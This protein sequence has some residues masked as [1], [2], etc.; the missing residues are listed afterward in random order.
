MTRISLSSFLLASVCAGGAL[1]QGNAAQG[2][3]LA[4]QICAACHVVSTDQRFAPTLNPPAA[5]FA[6]LARRDDM[7]DS[8]LRQILASHHEMVGE[9]GAMPNPQLLDYQIDAIVKYFDT[10]RK[11]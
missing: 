7:T 6:S 10:L 5:S 11:R 2:L 3:K 1:A 8:N 4:R 9:S